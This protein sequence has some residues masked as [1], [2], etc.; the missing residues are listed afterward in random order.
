MM[1][2]V[3]TT[4]TIWIPR[5]KVDCEGSSCGDRAVPC[6][7]FR[8]ALARRNVLSSRSFLDGGWKIY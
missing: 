7:T 2:S 5:E 6:G 1:L 3:R 4:V 8:S